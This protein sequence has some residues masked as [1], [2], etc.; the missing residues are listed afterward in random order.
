MFSGIFIV[1]FNAIL[2]VRC[3]DRRIG[4]WT[5]FCSKETVSRKTT[6]IGW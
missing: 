5:D 2:T 6:V 1:A 3:T 4:V